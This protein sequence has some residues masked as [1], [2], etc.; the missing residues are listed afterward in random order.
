MGGTNRGSGSGKTQRSW[1]GRGAWVVKNS[2]VQVL[3][4]RGGG[5]KHRGVWVVGNRQRSSEEV[6]SRGVWVV[7]VGGDWV[8]KNRGARAVKDEGFKEVN[9]EEPGRRQRRWCK[10]EESGW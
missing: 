6:K 2:G 9:M 10:T 3:N 4:R 1:G 7:N 8:V 5:L